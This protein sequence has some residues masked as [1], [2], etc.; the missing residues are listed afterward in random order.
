ERYYPD[1]IERR[2]NNYMEAMFWACFTYDCKGPCHIYHKE[3]V[4]QKEVN[5][6]EMDRINED[7]VEA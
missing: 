5:E 4:E 7:E 3:M 1:Y 2:Y 6:D